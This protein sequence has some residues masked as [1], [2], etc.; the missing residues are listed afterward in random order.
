MKYLRI[1][2]IK[3]VLNLDNKNK[4]TNKKTLLKEIKED[5]IFLGCQLL[6]NW[7]VDSTQFQL[8]SQ[9]VYL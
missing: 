3:Y 1:N 4:K 2:L 9:Q 8:K 5:L 7:S 6:P